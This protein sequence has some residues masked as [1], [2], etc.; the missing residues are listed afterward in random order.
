[1]EEFR[2]KEI[3]V[4]FISHARVRLQLPCQQKFS[5]ISR[6]MR[7]RGIYSTVEGVSCREISEHRNFFFNTEKLFPEG[8]SRL[9]VR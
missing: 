2:K 8:V 5:A 4:A 3:L 7:E 6:W 9:T 1:V